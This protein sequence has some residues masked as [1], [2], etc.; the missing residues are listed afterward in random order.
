VTWI[1]SIRRLCQVKL[2]LLA[3]VCTFAVAGCLGVRFAPDP[4]RNGPT[5]L[6]C[7]VL[8]VGGGIGGLHTAL[9]LGEKTDFTVCLFE[10]RARL[11]GRIFDVPMN[12]ETGSP[13]FGLG[14]RRF[15][16]DQ[17]LMVGL[18]AELGIEFDNPPGSDTLVLARGASNYDPAESSY[19]NDRLAA[20][21]FSSLTQW[22]D[23]PGQPD[24]IE[25]KLWDLIR[26]YHHV[27]PAPAFGEWIRSKFGKDV[28]EFLS[29][30]WGFRG[31][32]QYPVDARSYLDWL[33]GNW[34]L[35]ATLY[36]KGGMGEF[37]RRIE[38]RARAAGVEIHTSE[39]IIELSRS[40]TGYEAV[41]PT[42]RVSASSVVIAVGANALPKIQGDVVR[43]LV[44]SKIFKEILPIKVVT[45]TQWWPSKWWE[46]D[47]FRKVAGNA[48][49][50]LS[51]EGCI[52]RLEFPADRY[53]ATRAVTRTVY[54]DDIECVVYWERLASESMAKVE[55]QISAELN[56]ILPGVPI[57]DP[58]LT[59]VTV[60]PA[61]WYWLSSK[62]SIRNADVAEWAAR[63]LAGEAVSLVGDA[64]CPQH[65][66]WS[67][68][69][70]RSSIRTL[71]LNYGLNFPEL[72]DLGEERS[73][74][75]DFLPQ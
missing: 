48:R 68:A 14:A 67:D 2:A 26:E 59:R 6:S 49:V 29:S 39:P 60:W 72:E 73:M 28:Y 24:D 56:A 15:K 32:F 35:G 52:T 42:Y 30:T 43:D 45:I 34:D 13:S 7:D 47:E 41:T 19:S 11:G 66:T 31:D 71:E 16:E 75:C 25:T 70:V 69:A 38:E 36:P 4:P 50:V 58:A 33:A 44:E 37:V 40:G 17:K 57:P 22:D 3:I 5:P 23:G 21:A 53:S 12:G 9:R 27:V 10:K 55:N 74:A 8:I 61:A 64:Y 20:D 46:G 65:A 62:A 54:S 63:P 1:S 18:A 51:D